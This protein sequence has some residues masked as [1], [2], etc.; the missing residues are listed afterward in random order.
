EPRFAKPRLKLRRLRVPPGLGRR[1]P[2][3]ERTTPAPATRPGIDWLLGD[4]SMNVREFMKAGHTPS[5]LSAFLY[6]DTSFMV[7]VLLGALA[8]S[9]APEF[10]L[11]D[12]QRGL[13]VAVP[14]LGGAILRVVLGL[15]TDHIGAKRTGIIGLVL[16]LIPLLLGW[17]WVDSYSKML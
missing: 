10:E 8:N 2:D 4:C 16:T 13:M 17:L 9:I 1:R 7:W 6:F 11:D 15:F 3:A 14:L 12:A 5:L